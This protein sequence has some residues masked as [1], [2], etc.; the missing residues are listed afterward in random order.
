MHKIGIIGNVSIRA[1]FVYSHVCSFFLYLQHVMEVNLKLNVT[2]HKKITF[3][4][5]RLIGVASSFPVAQLKHSWH[6]CIVESL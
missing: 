4:G 3:K 5:C 2:W 6:S 1:Y